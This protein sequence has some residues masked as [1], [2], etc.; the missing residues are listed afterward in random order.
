MRPFSECE[1]L[2]CPLEKIVLKIKKLDQ[3]ERDIILELEAPIK[4]KKE[5]ELEALNNT[6]NN[7]NR[8]KPRRELTLD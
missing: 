7:N 1:M 2:R 6:N 5:E 8:P 4:V 3:L